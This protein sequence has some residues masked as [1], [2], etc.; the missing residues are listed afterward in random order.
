[1]GDRVVHTACFVVCMLLLV[2]CGKEVR[3]VSAVPVGFSAGAGWPES[4]AVT[5]DEGGTTF[6]D[7]DMMSVFAFYHQGGNAASATEFMNNQMVGL[8]AGKWG[9]SPVKY[10]PASSADRLS[11]YGVFPY[12]ASGKWEVDGST[13][14]LFA[15]HPM[16][17]RTADGCIPLHFS[18]VLNRFRFRF[19][20]GDGYGDGLN[21]DRVEILNSCAS[22][23]FDRNTKTVDLA[24]A[25]KTLSLEGSFSI[26]DPDPDNAMAGLCPESLYARI[27]DGEKLRIRI[28]AQGV[29]Y[30]EI[31]LTLPS[32]A[33]AFLYT[34]TFTGTGVDFSSDVTI[35]DW[36]EYCELDDEGRDIVNIIK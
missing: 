8:D 27:P 2:S 29:T 35:E 13:D 18:H 19:L 12:S 28:T 33:K 4:R 5:D 3:D 32:A 11:F 31:P 34:F 14:I 30:D 22:V 17:S 10:W 24:A 21:V 20:R 6:E 25:I 36:G 1:M 23:E 7:G 16:M 26:A 9:Y 15:E